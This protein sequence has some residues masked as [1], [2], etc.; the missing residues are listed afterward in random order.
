MTSAEIRQAAAIE[1]LPG[2]GKSWLCRAVVEADPGW[3]TR[4]EGVADSPLLPLYYAQPARWALSF[5]LDALAR[6]LGLL[7]RPSLLQD[8]SLYGDLAIARAVHV[9]GLL[10]GLE[11]DLYR[12]W[13]SQA[14]QVFA[15]H[16]QLPQKI[17]WLDAPAEV[18]L[19]RALARGRAGEDFSLSWLTVV[20][21][22]YEVA[23]AQ[24]GADGLEVIRVPWDPYGSVDAVL[25]LLK[26]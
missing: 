17:I 21:Q 19:E 15:L 26:R 5:Q 25:G 18:C 1:G 22:Q 7:G 24:A 13:W 10:T 23:M 3:V 11:W 20:A 6:Q 16:G 2:V 9:M 14:R 8:R 12:R 4:P